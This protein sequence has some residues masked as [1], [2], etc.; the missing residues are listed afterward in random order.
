MKTTTLIIAGLALACGGFAQE[1]KENPKQAI[2]NL[3]HQ[4]GEAKQAGRLDEAQKLHAEAERL[5]AAL[6]GKETVKKAD[7]HPEGGKFAGKGPEAERLQHIMQAVEHLR[8]A[9]LNEPAQGI[10]Q[11]AQNMRREIEERMKRQQAEAHGK[12]G[13]HPG[14]EKPHAEL[15]EMRQ[16][17]RRMAE[18]IEQ[19][20]AELKKRTP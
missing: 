13:K 7:K 20:Q 12:E 2:E 9:G 4:A 19:L 5:M 6:H 16:Q 14:G 8:A 11:I 3:M 17:M 1:T 18:Q 10:E 15:E